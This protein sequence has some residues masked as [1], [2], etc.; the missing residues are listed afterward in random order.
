M[1][2]IAYAQMPLTNV[3]S[4]IFRGAIGLILGLSLHLFFIICVCE[5]LS[6]EEFSPRGWVVFT[7]IFFISRLGLFIRVQNF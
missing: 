5:L 1:F 2:L 7:L 3:H 6:I 4:D